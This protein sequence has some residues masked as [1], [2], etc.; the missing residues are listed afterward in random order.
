MGD[1]RLGPRGVSRRAVSHTQL[2]SRAQDGA[3]RGPFPGAG[4]HTCLPRRTVR[5]GPLLRSHSSRMR[6]RPGLGLGRAPCESPRIPSHRTPGSQTWSSRGWGGR[7]TPA[8]KPDLCGVQRARCPGRGPSTRGA[9]SRP[10]PPCSSSWCWGG[11]FHSAFHRARDICFSR[12]GPKG[13]RA[14]VSP[15]LVSTTGQQH[16]SSRGVG[17]RASEEEGGAGGGGGA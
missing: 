12:D 13:G 6:H 16:L 11:A 15:P 4:G 7:Q 2:P 5:G 14:A 1:H 3:W 10:Q 17:S 8:G 9:G